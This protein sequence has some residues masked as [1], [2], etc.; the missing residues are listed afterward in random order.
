MSYF[1]GFYLDIISIIF[2]IIYPYDYPRKYIISNSWD[3]MVPLLKILV[4][5]SLHQ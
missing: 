1:Q 2:M 4:V 5:I 3:I